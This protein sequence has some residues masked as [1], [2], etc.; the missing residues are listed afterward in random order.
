MQTSQP[1]TKQ[2]KVQRQT[3]EVYL[4][5][6]NKG[7]AIKLARKKARQNNQYCDLDHCSDY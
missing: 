6:K 2:K 1:I 4:E 3:N 5:R 7:K